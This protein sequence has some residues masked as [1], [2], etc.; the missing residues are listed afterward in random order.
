MITREFKTRKIITLDF[1]KSGQSTIFIKEA[2]EI[3][4]DTIVSSI[5]FFY[6]TYYDIAPE[7]IGSLKKMHSLLVILNK[8]LGYEGKKIF[9]VHNKKH[10]MNLWDVAFLGKSIRRDVIRLV[11]KKHIFSREKHNDFRMGLLRVNLATTDRKGNWNMENVR[12]YAR[13]FTVFCLAHNAHPGN[14]KYLSDPSVYKK[15]IMIALK[16]PKVLFKKMHT[17]YMPI[18]LKKIKGNWGKILRDEWSN[19]CAK[20]EFEGELNINN[21][22][23]GAEFC[24]AFSR[25]EKEIIEKMCPKKDDKKGDTEKE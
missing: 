4:V 2:K 21:E 18:Y 16:R 3:E 12:E 7:D 9:D 6:S 10:I 23:D 14:N 13:L 5:R 15:N 25:F 11:W 17:K 22:I 1:V 20:F 24:L 19:T 8:A